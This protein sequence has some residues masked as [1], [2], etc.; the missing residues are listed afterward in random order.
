MNGNRW[1]THN[2]SNPGLPDIHE[3]LSFAY[4]LALVRPSCVLSLRYAK[5][6]FQGGGTLAFPLH[7]TIIT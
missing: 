3:E 1:N 7:G 6:L 4:P 2:G 5:R